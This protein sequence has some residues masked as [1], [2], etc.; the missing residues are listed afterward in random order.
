MP[1]GDD[2]LEADAGEVPTPD[3]GGGVNGPNADASAGD[4]TRI[5]FFGGSSTGCAAAR[6][7][8]P[9]SGIVLGALLLLGWVRTRRRELVRR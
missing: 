9:A 4:A 8:Q 6:R 2:A 5:D 7:A 1:F 3:T